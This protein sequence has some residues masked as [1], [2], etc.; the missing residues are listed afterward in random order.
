MR[1]ALLRLRD[2]RLSAIG[3]AGL[4]LVTAFIAAATPRLVDHVADDTLRATVAEAPAVRRTIR[5]VQEDR[6]PADDPADPFSAIKAR[7]ASLFAQ[8]PASIQALIRERGWT[9]NSGRWLVP[10]VP[11]DPA[12]MRIQIE[13]GAMD[14][15]R[16]VEGRWPTGST[17]KVPDGTSTDAVPPLVT[18]FEVA[19]STETAAGFHLKLGDILT[20]VPDRTDELVGQLGGADIL[21]IAVKL[22]GTY[23]VMDEADPWWLN[24]TS[25]ARP[26]IRSLGGDSRI[27]DSTALLSPDAYAAYMTESIRGALFVQY[28]FRDYV[29]PARLVSSAV[30]GLLA[31]VKR[32][33]TDFPPSSRPLLQHLGGQA[34]LSEGLR[35][36]LETYR[37]QWASATAILT[38]GGIGPGAVAIGA[39]ALVAGLAAR[40]RRSALALS[41][42]RGAS[43]SQ[44]ILAVVAEGLLLTGPVALAAVAAAFLVI[45]ARPVPASPLAGLGVAVLAT[46]LLVIATVPATSGPAFGPARELAVPRR[47]TPRRLLFEGLLVALALAGAYLLRERGLRGASS[48]GKLGQADAFVAAAPALIGIAAG[49]LALRLFPYPLRALAWLARRGRGLVP[50]L[51]MRRASDGRRTGP[52]LVVLLV[53]AA[54]WAFSSSVL[55]YVDRAADAVAWRE[56]GAA[57]RIDSTTG[58]FPRDFDPARLPQVTAT[59]GVHREVVNMGPRYLNVQVLAIPVA[60]FDRVTA[61]TPAAL[62][63]PIDL[64]ATNV[65]AIPIVV[66]KEV[67]ARADGVKPG[68]DFQTYV[69]GYLYPMHV[70]GVIDQLPGIATNNQFAIASRDQMVALR[71]GSILEPSVLFARAPAGAE[72][73]IRA[74][75]QAAVPVGSS[76]TAQ[77]AAAA[78]IR[79]TPTARAVVA[80]MAVAAVVAFAYAVL[81]MAAALALAGAAEAVETAHLRTLGLTG[82][83]A[84]GLVLVENAPV[85]ATAVGVGLALGLAT[86]R[87]LR[88][89]LGLEAFIGSQADIPLTLDPGQLAIVLGGI[90]GVVVLGFAVGTLMQRGAAPTAAVRRGFE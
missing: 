65:S 49:L 85:V 78:A 37:S 55:L 3:L 27:I 89:G 31:D 45:P 75:V 4:V 81:A 13:P 36:L 9:A 70:V 15:L 77:A 23:K 86:F 16:L 42:G 52:G 76:V 88:Q 79:T 84:A 74:A 61:G 83:Q 12:T 35:V 80:G 73:A 53:T 62:G 30:D 41:R 34:R 17:T 66:S 72:A 56:T 38:I 69:E 48:A 90:V 25:L 32:L 29:E 6:L 44:V 64:Y 40:R 51:A 50:V 39:L 57:Y 21:N 7:E 68:D 1:L 19:L 20:P 67:A 2:E 63:L 47:P 59:V 33:E 18:A 58:L 71:P 82:R 24:D 26:A 8:L 10:Q 22:T 28:T 87:F 46:L 11:G 60:A 54:I 43:L 5:L 14:R